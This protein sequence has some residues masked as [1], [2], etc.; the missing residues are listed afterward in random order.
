MTVYEL[1]QKLESFDPELEVVVWDAHYEVHQDEL[2]LELI[3]DYYHY[4][5]FG[6][7]VKDTA[8]ELR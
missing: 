8:L 6:K 1:M 7:W 3:D 4:D 5:E 2:Q